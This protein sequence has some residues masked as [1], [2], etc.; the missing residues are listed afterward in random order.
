MFNLKKMLR[1][2][3]G[4]VT[5]EYA[6]VIVPFIISVLFIMELCRVTY[7][8]SAV[9]L[10]LAE[11]SSAAAT[12]S[13][14]SNGTDYFQRMIKKQITESPLLSPGDLDVTATV[15]YCNS[16]QQL[17]DNKCATG[18]GDSAP[19]SIY[20]ISVPYKP[21]FFIFPVSFL[22]DKMT[23]KIIMVQEYHVVREDNII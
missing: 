11:S 2:C 1:N 19:L 6:L 9:D 23:R 15:L 10:V 17:L 5:V 13:N 22:S 18:G 16:I 3:N 21:L 20:E 4:S 8:M 7:I 12:L 14:T